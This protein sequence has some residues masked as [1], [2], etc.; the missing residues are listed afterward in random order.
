MN[1]Y[2]IANDFKKKF[3]EQNENVWSRTMKPTYFSINGDET[4]A[5][6]NPYAMEN[7]EHALVV[8][9]YTYTVITQEDCCMVPLFFNANGEIEDYIEIEG[10]KLSFSKPIT[11]LSRYWSTHCYISNDKLN[12]SITVKAWEFD[13]FFDR[14]WKLFSVARTC[15]TQMELDFAC[16]IYNLEKDILEL[17][18]KNIK[19]EAE[20]DAKN[21]LIS[22][23]QELLDRIEEIT[24]PKNQD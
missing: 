20:L 22:A 15:K 6:T 3:I 2:E 11:A 8:F 14:I 12:A 5:S 17:K 4:K 23:H 13:K 16:K 9:H 19:Q 21:T 1:R 7:A 18:E 10:W 24:N